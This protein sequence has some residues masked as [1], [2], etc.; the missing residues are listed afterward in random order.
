MTGGESH[1]VI[2][3]LVVRRSTLRTWLI[4]LA[5]IPALVIGIDIVWRRRIVAWL[6]ERIFTSD[7]Q[8]LEF[9]DEIWA[10]ALV[11]MGGAVVIWGLKE[12]F[13]PVPVLRTD[14]E[15]VHIRMLGPFRP[16]TTLPWDSLHDVDAGSLEDDGDP[17]D[18][19]VIEVNDGALLP[20]NPWAGRRFDEHTLALYSL[21]WDTSAE[22]VAEILSSQAL[23]VAR[24]GRSES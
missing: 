10:W 8:L 7:P 16:V 9:R 5:G 18:V 22:D 3:P 20:L 23:A 19:L 4:A 11:V 17:L 12:L 15:G 6:T 24:L 21:E 1:P 2:E 14:D 13:D